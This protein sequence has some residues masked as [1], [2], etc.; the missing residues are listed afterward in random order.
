MNGPCIADPRQ[1]SPEP[2]TV[3]PDDAREGQA[4]VGGSQADTDAGVE[5]FD[6]ET[7]LGGIASF[8]WGGRALL[9][10][11]AHAR[12]RAIAVAGLML[13]VAVPGGWVLAQPEAS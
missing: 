11:V 7:N 10:R 6:F 8:S 1:T 3:E 5:P 12:Q 2:S 4:P 9:R 13:A